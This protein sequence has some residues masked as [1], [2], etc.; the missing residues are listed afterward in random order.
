[1]TFLS[2]VQQRELRDVLE[3]LHRT[4]DVSLEVRIHGARER[5]ERRMPVAAIAQRELAGRRP[6]S[7]GATDALLLIILRTHEFAVAVD[8]VRWFPDPV[9]A[10]WNDAGAVLSTAFA[11][12]HPVEGMR[13]LVRRLPELLVRQSQS[14]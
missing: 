2:S 10:R 9:A 5:N 13:G 7:P 14:H 12:G 11:A 1:M 4:H 8:A 3:D 6:E